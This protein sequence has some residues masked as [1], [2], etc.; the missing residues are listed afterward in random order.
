[1]ITTIMAVSEA[2]SSAE[3]RSERRSEATK[4]AP[5]DS[6]QLRGSPL[7][8]PDPKRWFKRKVPLLSGN[9]G[10]KIFIASFQELQEISGS[11]RVVKTTR[12]TYPPHTPLDSF[13]GLVNRFFFGGV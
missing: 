7:A 4:E 5:K 2:Q 6:T 10:S 12:L 9:Y 13:K 8:K 3:G 11:E 1:M